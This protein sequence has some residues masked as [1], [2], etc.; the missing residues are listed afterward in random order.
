M[1]KVGH[2]WNIRAYATN[3]GDNENWTSIHR[4]IANCFNHKANGCSFSL[5]T[6]SDK[7]LQVTR[8]KCSTHTDLIFSLQVTTTDCLLLSQVHPEVVYRYRQVQPWW[9][10]RCLE[11]WTK[12]QRLCPTVGAVFNI[13]SFTCMHLYNQSQSGITPILLEITDTHITSTLSMNRFD[14]KDLSTCKAST[15]TILAGSSSW[16]HQRLLTHSGNIGN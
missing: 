9:W 15:T 5:I 6:D 14:G 1:F 3:K 12:W 8:E 16:C 7:F 11:S 13:V 10:L 4:V 2:F